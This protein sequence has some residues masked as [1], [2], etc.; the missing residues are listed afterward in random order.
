[1][2]RRSDSLK[3]DSDTLSWRPPSIYYSEGSLDT[4]SLFFPLTCFLRGRSWD[5]SR[6]LDV[7]FITWVRQKRPTKWLASPPA[8][9]P[10]PASADANI[11]PEMRKELGRGGERLRCL[12]RAGCVR[13]LPRDAVV[14][15]IGYP[16]QKSWGQS[17]LIQLLSPV[18]LW[19]LWSTAVNAVA[20]LAG[21]SDRSTGADR[22]SSNRITQCSCRIP[23][24]SPSAWRI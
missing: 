14:V 23:M 1:M 17:V 21:G 12:R 9:P 19:I 2:P 22:D 11:L 13:G 10:Q 24:P 3:Y 8:S 16:I 4:S 7:E 20:S 18:G 6:L 15:P 5:G